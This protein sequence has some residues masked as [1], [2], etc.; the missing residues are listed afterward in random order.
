[1]EYSRQTANPNPQG[2]SGFAWPDTSVERDRFVWIELGIK[3]GD[4]VAAAAYGHQMV[5][6]ARMGFPYVREYA[7]D[8]PEL[9]AQRNKKALE[10]L[11][12]AASA[13]I[14]DAY[15]IMHLAHVSGA[16]GLPKN[17]MMAHTC[18]LVFNAIVPS[19]HTRRHLMESEKNLRHG[20]L[21]SAQSRAAVPW[22][23]W[24]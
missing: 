12:S 11:K 14:A 1:M 18:L 20:D 9:I 19:N 7:Q 22:G 4:P 21:L 2:A 13:G 8:H 3:A 24:P 16:L 23:C 15:W 5:E 10:H 6:F 17:P